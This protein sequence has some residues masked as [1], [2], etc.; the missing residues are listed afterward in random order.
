[1]TVAV[2]VLGIVAV[3]PLIVAAEWGKMAS[4]PAA[5][6]AASVAAD[7]ALAGHGAEGRPAKRPGESTA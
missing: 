5:S 3:A 2:M 6:V 4:A 1:M 7:A